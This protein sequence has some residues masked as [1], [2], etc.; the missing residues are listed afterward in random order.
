[1]KYAFNLKKRLIFFE[2]VLMKIFLNSVLLL[3]LFLSFSIN[4]SSTTQLTQF[5]QDSNK[6]QLASD[7]QSALKNEE[8]HVAVS[9]TDGSKSI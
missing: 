3:S 1:M 4:A 7:S 5:P 6:K 2:R 8:E 9:E